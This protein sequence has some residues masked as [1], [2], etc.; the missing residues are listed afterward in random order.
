M[1]YRKRL[2][3]R[4]NSN[5]EHLPIVSAERLVALGFKLMNEAD[6]VGAGSLTGRALL[7]RDGLLITFL[8]LC[9][10]RR[11]NI[12][13]MLLDVHLQRTGQQYSVLFEPEETKNGEPLEFD[14]PRM[15]VAHFE[16]YLDHWRPLIPGSADHQGLWAS[17]KKCRLTKCALNDI[18]VRHSR[19]AWGITVNLHRFR[20][21]AATTLAIHDPAR[22][23]VAKDLLHHKA[24]GSVGRH[25]N[26]AASLQAS[27][28][29]AKLL[30]QLRQKSQT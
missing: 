24:P 29:Y 7:Y 19:R 13:A 3:R 27:R 28:S 21:A 12:T 10:I 14:L 18:V 30:Q 22:V 20:H 11:R 4:T 2:D 9:P 5:R 6:E 25:Y 8:A 26:L 1:I 17:E 15:I 16:R 23:L